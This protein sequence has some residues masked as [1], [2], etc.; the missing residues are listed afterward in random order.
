MATACLAAG[1]R[2]AISQLT[3]WEI[4][5]GLIAA[6]LAGRATRFS[7][8]CSLLH[9]AELPPLSKATHVWIG[10]RSAGRH[11]GK[12]DVDVLLVTTA[13]VNGWGAVSNDKVFRNAA[14]VLG[15]YLEDWIAPTR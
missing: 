13:I 3:I 8:L 4:Q 14:D 2:L 10:L 6:G 9:V 15:L 1:H 12:E 7:H 11:P 5:R